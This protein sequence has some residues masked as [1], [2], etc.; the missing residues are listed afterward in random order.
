MIFNTA[1]LALG[2]FLKLI[3]NVCIHAVLELSVFGTLN[4]SQDVI[5]RYSDA[6]LMNAEND[7]SGN[8]GLLLNSGWNWTPR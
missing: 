6:A 1:F 7:S 4:F 3:S 8:P 2:H 5:A